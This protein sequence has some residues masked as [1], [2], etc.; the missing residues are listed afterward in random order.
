[1]LC[2]TVF[3]F[4]ILSYDTQSDKMLC[5]VPKHFMLKYH[6]EHCYMFRSLMRSSSG[7]HIKVTFHKTEVTRG[8]TV[9]SGTALQAERS[10]V[11]FWMVLLGFFIPSG[12]TMSLGSAQPLTEMSTRNISWGVRARCV[13]LTTWP[14][15]RA[16]CLEIWEHQTLWNSKGL[17]RPVM[18]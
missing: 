3:R 11:R 12:R 8:G 13:G 1:V 18:G 7:N 4:T 9:G 14:P 6:V 15:S 17:S 2:L 5:I 10:R 16:D